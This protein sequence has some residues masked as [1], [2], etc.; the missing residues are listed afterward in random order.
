MKSVKHISKLL[1]TF[2]FLLVFTGI[3][4]AAVFD[5]SNPPPG[6]VGGL[7]LSTNDLEYRPATDVD[8]NPGGG[9]GY[10]PW[11]EAGTYQGDLIEYDIDTSGKLTTTVDF[12]VS[13]PIVPVGG[14]W[15]ARVLIDAMDWDLDRKI[16]TRN[17]GQQVAFRWPTF[18]A[19]Q[20]TDLDPVT[21]ATDPSSPIVDFLRGDRINEQPVG[22][23]RQ[24]F[25]AMG[26]NMHSTP[27]YVAQPVRA[28]S[29]GNY[30]T[31]K[32]NN[33]SRAP[34]VYMSSNDVMVHA[35]DAITGSEVYA[36]VPS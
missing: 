34:R 33:A 18:S 22:V 31:F 8:P 23:L 25:S 7:A 5:P 35:F 10:R 28:F 32:A 19:T 14:N 3:F 4:A 17:A 24:R 15:S 11:Y 27:V 9:K 36:Y 2:G 1:I 21:L 16:I 13:P 26:D 6:Y 29:F 30:L 12:S 20:Q